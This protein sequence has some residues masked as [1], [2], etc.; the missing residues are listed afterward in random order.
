VQHRRLVQVGQIGHVLGLLEFRR[1]HLGQLVLAEL[2]R[3]REIPEFLSYLFSHSFFYSFI[4]FFSDRLPSITRHEYASSERSSNDMSIYFE[5]EN[6]D[7]YSFIM[8]NRRDW[9]IWLP[10]ASD[11]Q[12][13]KDGTKVIRNNRNWRAFDLCVSQI[14][15]S[16]PLAIC[17]R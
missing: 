10:P 17:F 11:L 7:K 8:S 4:Y 2:F 16:L 9:N 3:L 12:K 6:E 13:D 15:V 14:G 5:R 1:V